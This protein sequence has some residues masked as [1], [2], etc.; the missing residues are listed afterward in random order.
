MA[1]LPTGYSVTHGLMLER[2]CYFPAPR[3]L[4]GEAGSLGNY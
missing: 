1:T 3:G 4:K 2:T